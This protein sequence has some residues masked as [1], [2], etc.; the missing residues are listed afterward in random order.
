MRFVCT[1]VQ[2]NANRFGREENWISIRIQ[3][4]RI[5]YTGNGELLTQ[6]EKERADF[7]MLLQVFSTRELMGDWGRRIAQ[8]EDD[9]DLQERGRLTAER[10]GRLRKKEFTARMRREL[11]EKISG[12]DAARTMSGRYTDDQEGYGARQR[13]NGES[14]QMEI[15]RIHER[16][17]RT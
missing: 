17:K 11:Q 4:L 8:A 5:L 3:G 2:S 10:I 15:E 12:E 7:A 1:R 16:Q 6:C 9:P 13:G 14:D